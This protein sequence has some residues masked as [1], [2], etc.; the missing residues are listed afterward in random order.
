MATEFSDVQWTSYT[1]EA[2]SLTDVVA[3]IAALPE[4]RQGRVEPQLQ[5]RHRRQRERSTR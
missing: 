5:L 3:A 4:G 2:D 1:V